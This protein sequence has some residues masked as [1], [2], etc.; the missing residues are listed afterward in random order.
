MRDKRHYTHAMS[1]RTLSRPNPLRL[2]RYA[3]V[4]SYASKYP[5]NELTVWCPKH[6]P[7]EAHT[8]EHYALIRLTHE[9]IAR[10]H[11]IVH[12]SPYG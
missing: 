9:D 2:A 12:P 5:I 6:Y 8:D 11:D 10:R 1:S 7:Y 3:L 4:H